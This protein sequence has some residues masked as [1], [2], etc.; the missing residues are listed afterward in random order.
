[1]AWSI[2]K[3][4][5]LRTTTFNGKK[6]CLKRNTKK[7]QHRINIRKKSRNKTRIILPHPIWVVGAGCSSSITTMQFMFGIWFQK[8]PPV[9]TNV[10]L[11][12]VL[13]CGCL[14]FDVLHSVFILFI[15]CWMYFIIFMLYM[16]LVHFVPFIFIFVHLFS[17]CFIYICV[18]FP[19]L[20]SFPLETPL[21]IQTTDMPY[22]Y[23]VLL[24]KPSCNF[25]FI[26]F[27]PLPWIPESINEALP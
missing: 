21:P 22:N 11:A 7:Q 15:V 24:N 13:F 14:L 17:I 6:K 3:N 26:G 23:F 25:I 5:S 16:F 19:V 27:F 8:S 2:K 1:M 20:H 4:N 12:C 10:Y 9:V 18:F